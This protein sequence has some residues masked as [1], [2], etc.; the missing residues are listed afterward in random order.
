MEEENNFDKYKTWSISC[1]SLLVLWYFFNIDLSKYFEQLDKVMNPYIHI[2]LIIVSIYFLIESILE[3]KKI[4]KEK[5]TPLKIQYYF[6]VIFFLI[7]LLICYPKLIAN[8]PITITSRLDLSIIIVSGYFLTITLSEI[9]NS[10]EHIIVFY[11]FRKTVMSILFLP[12]VVSLI[13]LFVIIILFNKY[14]SFFELY[15]ILFLLL[16]MIISYIFCIDKG[17]LYNKENMQYLDK[18][19]KSLNRQVE[20]SESIT[21]EEKDELNKIELKTK[22]HKNIMKNINSKEISFFDNLSMRYA[23]YKEINI[24]IKDKEILINKENDNEKIVHFEIYDSIS[25]NV[26]QSVDIEFKYLKKASEEI[27]LPKTK[28]CEQHLITDLVSYAYKLKNYDTSDK[29]ELLFATSGKGLYDDVKKI[30][31][32]DDKNIDYI[33]E[34]GWSP[35]LIATANGHYKVVKLLLEYAAEPNICNY[36][37]ATPLIFASK[38]GKK[39]LCKLLL[40]YNADINLPDMK[41]RTPL[42]WASEEGHLSVIEILIDNGV[43]ISLKSKENL[44]AIDYAKKAHN[45][46]IYRLLKSKP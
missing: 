43:N 45:G 44:S 46:K 36:Y 17:K 2:V 22:K 28:D 21:D 12:L 20:V 4:K 5:S 9:K 13:I 10:V 29:N 42:M 37:G 35:L 31:K 15:N 11:K 38:Y 30:L 40:N 6:V 3:Y 41:G 14:S 39:S 19:N 8:T 7:S 23:F 26:Q 16:S 1:S 18:L 25:G 24:T 33:A 32:C 27:D 34:N